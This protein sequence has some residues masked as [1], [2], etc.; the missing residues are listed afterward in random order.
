[1]LMEKLKK[2][3]KDKKMTQSELAMLCGVSRNSLVNWETGKITPKIGDIERLSLALGISPSELI[4]DLPRSHEEGVYTVGTGQ[5]KGLAYWGGVADEAR[6]VAERGNEEE[7]RMIEPLLA[8]AYKMLS[9][10]MKKLKPS[11]SKE[12]PLGVSAYNGSHSS[13]AGNSLIVEPA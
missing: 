11:K 2:I 7:M 12:A 6:R 1:M 4:E 10:G 5:P 9:S 8:M 13:Y 3:R